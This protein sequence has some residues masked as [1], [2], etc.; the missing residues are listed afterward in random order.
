VVLFL[1]QRNKGLKRNGKGES[2]SKRRRLRLDGRGDDGSDWGKGGGNT[3]Y[4]DRKR[5]ISNSDH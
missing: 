1:R 2:Q 4:G 5:G 3:G